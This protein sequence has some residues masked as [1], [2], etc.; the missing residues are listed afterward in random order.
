MSKIFLTI[1]LIINI[2]VGV[3]IYQEIQTAQIKI[4]TTKNWAEVTR[5]IKIIKEQDDRK[6]DRDEEKQDRKRGN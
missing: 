2:L 1:V 6:E 3:C 4:E 5:Y